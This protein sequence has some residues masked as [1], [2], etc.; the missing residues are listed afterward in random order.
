MVRAV[1]SVST[2]FYIRDH[3]PPVGQSFQPAFKKGGFKVWGCRGVTN[4]GCTSASIRAHFHSKHQNVFKHNLNSK[5]GDVFREKQGVGGMSLTT[6]CWLTFLPHALRDEERCVAVADVCCLP[7]A[8]AGSALERIRLR[9]DALRGRGCF[10]SRTEVH[11]FGLDFV[12]VYIYILYF[13]RL[14][15]VKFAPSTSFRLGHKFGETLAP[16]LHGPSHCVDFPRSLKSNHETEFP[17]SPSSSFSCLRYSACAANVSQLASQH[18]A[19]CSVRTGRG[20]QRTA[21]LMEQLSAL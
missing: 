10:I 12:Y 7:A 17:D 1:K 5:D 19:Y 20:A 9:A 8:V 2:P 18:H 21:A 13:L 3:L 6:C 16:C 11:D 14:R 15:K 4:D